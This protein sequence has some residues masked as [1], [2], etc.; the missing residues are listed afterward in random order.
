MFL[1][2]DLW[3]CCFTNGKLFSVLQGLETTRIP[4]FPQED[5]VVKTVLSLLPTSPL[6]QVPPVVLRS[7]SSSPPWSAWCVTDD[8]TPNI[9]NLT[10]LPYP[11]RPWPRPSEAVAGAEEVATTMDQSLA[12][13]SSRCGLL[14]PPTART[15]RKSAGTTVI[16][17]TSYRR[18]PLRV[19]PTS[20]TKYE[21]RR[22]PYRQLRWPHQP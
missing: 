19:Q 18:C 9:R 8:D 2:Y 7:S 10:T 12:T 6:S 16:R 20:T 3:S 14:T 22:R 21:N 5:R 11:S 17:S 4:E 15:T 13:S 1:L